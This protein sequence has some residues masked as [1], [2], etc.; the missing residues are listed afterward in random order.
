MTYYPS[1]LKTGNS[2]AKRR[3]L[4][5]N[6]AAKLV[7]ENGCK[8]IRACKDRVGFYAYIMRDHLGQKFYLI[9]KGSRL[10]KDIVSCQAHLPI[11]AQSEN[12][13]LVL[14]W[15]PLSEEDVRF[16]LF[17]PQQII[18]DNYGFNDRQGVRMINFS[19]KL[20]FAFDPDS[21]SVEMLYEKVKKIPRETTLCQQ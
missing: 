19:I 2:K 12:R 3:R 18:E 7:S 8:I 20:G 9:A 1:F 4:L 15:L 21:L 6:V 14:A 13:P 16:Y 10:F 17:E 5:E 11:R